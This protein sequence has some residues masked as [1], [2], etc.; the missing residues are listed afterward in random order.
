M[1][2][3]QAAALFI[4]GALVGAGLVNALVGRQIDELLLQIQLLRA[5]LF[6]LQKETDELREARRRQEYRLVESLEVRVRLLD[7]GFAS[8]ELNAIGLAVEKQ[9]SEWLQPLKGR[10][11][12]RLE[13]EVIPQI[14]DGREVTAE[15]FTFRLQT[16]LI[17]ISETLV[18]Q[19]EARAVPSRSKS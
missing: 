3:V 2:R 13:W 10:E 9:V 16:N 11:L 7:Q 15:G 8:Y 12:A 17:V 18:V 1:K 5:R 4:L 6:E 14:I 19:V